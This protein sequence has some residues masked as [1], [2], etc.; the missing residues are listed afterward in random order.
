MSYNLV[1]EDGSLKNIAGGSG[2]DNI[3]VYTTEEYE[4]IKDTIPEGTKFIISDD[5]QEEEKKDKDFYIFLSDSYDDTGYG[6]GWISRCAQ[7]LGLSSNQWVNMAKS[8]GSFQAGTWISRI[9]EYR[10]SITEEQAKKVTHIVLGGGI[11]DCLTDGVN[12]YSTEPSVSAYITKLHSAVN[13]F[14]SYV[15]TNF[16]NAVFYFCPVGYALES[17]TVLAGRGID[18]RQYCYR[19][20][21][22]VLTMVK[23]ARLPVGTEFVLH[24]KTFLFTGDY[25]HPNSNGCLQIARYIAQAVQNGSVYVGFPKRDVSITHSANHR[26]DTWYKL[27]E[28]LINDKVIIRPTGL[29]FFD[30]TVSVGFEWLDLGELDC[31]YFQYFDDTQCFV[32]MNFASGNN[33]NTMGFLRCNNRHLE[34]SIRDVAPTTWGYEKYS[35]VK[36]MNINVPKIIIP[37]NLG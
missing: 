6:G 16:P 31:N 20:I 3:P 24:N 15:N 29:T 35:D 5:Y 19:Y 17:S 2:G 11:N 18:S 33:V 26:D 9:T 21:R 32:S 28:E 14:M 8:G 7:F 10:E 30:F 27:N 37:A 23:N 22:E 25:L 34:L 36:I 1:Q 4:Q 13:T 12:N